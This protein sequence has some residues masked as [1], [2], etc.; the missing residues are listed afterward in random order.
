MRHQKTESQAL[1]RWYCPNCGQRY[2]GDH[3][4]DMCDFCQDFTTWKPLPPAKL[5]TTPT[6]SDSDTS[7]PVQLRLL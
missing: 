2:F 4:P 1:A 5:D 6:R 7:R 3:P